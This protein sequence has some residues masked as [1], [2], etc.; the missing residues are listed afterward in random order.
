MRGAFRAWL[1]LGSVGQEEF[2]LLNLGGFGNVIVLMDMSV[3]LQLV[4][5]KR[6]LRA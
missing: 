3:T 4:L 2:I 6:R 1:G 5:E